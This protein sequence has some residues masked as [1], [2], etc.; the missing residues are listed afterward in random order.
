MTFVRRVTLQLTPLL[1]LMLI[2][3]FAQ[4]MEV[5]MVAK[6]EIDRV[7][8]ERQETVDENEILRKRVDQ[9][10]TQQQEFD[11]AQYREREQLGQVV[12][13]LFRMPDSTL[14]KLIQPRSQTESGGL[15]S[16]EIADL[17]ARFQKL[18]NSTGEQVID[19]LLTFNEMRKQFDVWDFYLNEDGILQITIGQDRQQ[20]KSKVIE[21]PEIFVEVV[22]QVR[23]QFPPTKNSILILCS[24]GDC[25]LSHRLAMTRGLPSLAERMKND[26]QGTQSFEYAVFGYLKIMRR[27]IYN[28]FYGNIFGFSNITDYS[29]NNFFSNINSYISF[30]Y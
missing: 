16:T 9:W 4:Y 17:K 12:R 24:Y 2:V 13:E 30:V 5:K 6:Q 1:D 21:S 19:H 22:L 23:K 20:I 26:G 15:S 14:N 29:L 18:A 8:S 11:H 3:I 28:I 7:A 27:Y 10:E 25:Q